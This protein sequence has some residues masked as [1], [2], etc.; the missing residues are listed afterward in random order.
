MK[1][2]E[3]VENNKSS[4]LIYARNKNVIRIDSVFYQILNLINIAGPT[5]DAKIASGVQSASYA[6]RLADAGL[7]DKKFDPNAKRGRT[8]KKGVTTYSLTPKGKKVLTAL[9]NSTDYIYVDTDGNPIKGPL[10]K[11]DL[12]T[13]PHIFKK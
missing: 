10:T 3:I 11:Q 12:V 13:H 8:G 6:E 2:F 9:M 4:D 7:L 5:T 1:I